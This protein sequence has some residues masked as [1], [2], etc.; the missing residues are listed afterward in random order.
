MCGRSVLGFLVCGRAV[1]GFLVMP[2]LQHV[3]LA[4]P[5][6]LAGTGTCLEVCWKE[7]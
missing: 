2:D 1:L 3:P 6:L 4:T 7:A 5:A